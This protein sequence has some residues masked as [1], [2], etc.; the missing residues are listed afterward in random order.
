VIGIFR[1][2][3]LRCT[4]QRWVIMRLLICFSDRPQETGMD[5]RKSFVDRAA[6]DP[7]RSMRWR[8]EFANAPACAG[9]ITV[10][11]RTA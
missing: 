11:F 6:Q 2:A 9:D 7:H 5:A 3:S 4:L 1:I 8:W 10:M